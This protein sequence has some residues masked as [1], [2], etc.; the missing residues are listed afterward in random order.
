LIS[1]GFQAPTGAEPPPLEREKNLSPP[2][3][4]SEYAP[5]HSVRICVSSGRME[6]WIDIQSVTINMGIK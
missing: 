2:G 3:Q 5:E 1:G 6:L 4:I